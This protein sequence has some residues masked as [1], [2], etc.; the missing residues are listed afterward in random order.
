M[1]NQIKSLAFLSLAIIYS[2]LTYDNIKAFAQGYNTPRLLQS[3]IGLPHF[4]NDADS[5]LIDTGTKPLVRI[6]NQDDQFVCSGTVVSNKYILTA[7]HCLVDDYGKMSTQKYKIHILNSNLLAATMVI[8]SEAAAINTQT[9]YALMTG[10][11]SNVNRYKMALGN[12]ASLTRSKTVVTCGYPYGGEPICYGTN[13]KFSTYLF[14]VAT[15]GTLY[16]GMSG[17]PVYDLERNIILGVNSA[18]GQGFIIVSTLV[19]LFESLGVEH[20]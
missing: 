19:G 4:S 20:E 1:L 3:R 5:S 8:E 16:P 2:L 10:D 15:Q 13:A 17:G 18:A 7:A 6:H 9:D 12:A 11:F 14:R